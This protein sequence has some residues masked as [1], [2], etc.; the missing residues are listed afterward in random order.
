VCALTIQSWLDVLVSAVG[1]LTVIFYT[2][3][4]KAHFSSKSVPRGA[5]VI[6]LAVSV[7]TLWYLALT[8]WLEQPIPAA[9]VGLALQV[10]GF[11]LFWSAILASRTARLRL[12]FD[13]ENPRTLVRDGP[14]R[15]VRHPFYT[16]YIIFWS[17]WALA[18]WSIWA[19]PPLVVI[20]S[21]YVIA[22]RGEER[23]FSR[24]TM[25]DAYVDY[26]ARTGFFWP[27]FGPSN[28]TPKN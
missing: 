4:L 27:R 28:S 17:A 13:L 5:M 23:K 1:L 21:I 19:L 9:L 15:L 8:W 10:A 11:A 20:V 24:T 22:A 25:A 26:R 14:Y 7:T 3:A 6:S 18:I 12:A 16:S 2:W